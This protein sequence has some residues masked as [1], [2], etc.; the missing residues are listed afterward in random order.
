MCDVNEVAGYEW[1]TEASEKRRKYREGETGREI[2]R[3]FP[4]FSNR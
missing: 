1:R 2:V 3:S 4:F